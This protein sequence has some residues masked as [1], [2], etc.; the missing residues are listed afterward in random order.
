MPGLSYRTF[1]FNSSMSILNLRVG[2]LPSSFLDGGIVDEIDLAINRK[3]LGYLLTSY[4]FL[5]WVLRYVF[6][7]GTRRLA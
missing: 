3:M 2:F 5:S 1:G 7:A 6:R 4:P